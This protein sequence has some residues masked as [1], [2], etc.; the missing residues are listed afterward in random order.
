M[1]LA[2]YLPLFLIF[3]VVL[4]AAPKSLNTDARANRKALGNFYAADP[5]DR[6][7]S[8]DIHDNNTIV[9]VTNDGSEVECTYRVQDQ[10]SQ[11]VVFHVASPCCEYYPGSID[12]EGAEGVEVEVRERRAVIRNPNVAHQ[13][14]YEY[15]GRLH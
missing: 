4:S 9:M 5:S 2:S 3:T 15:L 13:F 8:F 6:V 1:L 7:H 10:A 14:A 11:F 12:G